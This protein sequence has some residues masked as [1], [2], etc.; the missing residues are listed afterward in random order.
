MI[1]S[2]LPFALY[3]IQHKCSFYISNHSVNCSIMI[4]TMP[5]STIYS[6]QQECS[7]W[8]LTTKSIV[9]SWL[10]PCRCPPYTP[11]NRSAPSTFRTTQ[12]IIQSW[13]PPCRR[14]PYTPF[15][16]RASSVFPTHPFNHSIML[17][18][19][20][21][22][23][24]GPKVP[25]QGSENLVNVSV[26]WSKIFPRTDLLSADN[27]LTFNPENKCFPRLVVFHPSWRYCTVL[28]WFSGTFH[29]GNNSRL[30]ELCSHIG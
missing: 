23:S 29:G 14:P 20:N 17:S 10:P 13:L 30:C 9:Q 28:R 1:A 11:F 15:N 4:A 26:P 27:A 3:S 16:K 12:S 8:I 18:A 22:D 7:F 24:H 25:W 2:L 6:I 5:P 21:R 19:R